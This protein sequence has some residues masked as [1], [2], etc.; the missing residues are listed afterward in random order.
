VAVPRWL[1]IVGSV[2]IVLHLGGLIVNSLASWSGPWPGPM[3]QVEGTP[4]AF[5]AAFQGEA[6]GNYLKLVRFTHNYHFPTDRTDAFEFQ[7]EFKL[8][9]RDG[10]EVA[11]VWLPD[12]SAN[13]WVRHRQGLLVRS[14]E[15]QPIPP[16]Q[17]EEIAG[18]GRQAPELTVWQGDETSGKLVSMP[19]HLVPR[20]RPVAQPTDYS[21]LMVKA[22]TRS[23]CRQHGAAS[24]EVIRHARGPVVSPLVQ[25]TESQRTAAHREMVSDYGEIRP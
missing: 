15:D 13:P 4:P 7:A 8:K 20:D 2:A 9:D 24:A 16:P 6:L 11:T 21:M 12:P 1:V 25:L 3:G 18:P 5:A 23:L 22:L 10:N 14:L 17:S 19:K